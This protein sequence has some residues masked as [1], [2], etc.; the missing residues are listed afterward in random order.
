MKLEYRICYGILNV[1]H[2]S[3][4]SLTILIELDGFLCEERRMNHCGK[5]LEIERDTGMK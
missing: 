3:I 1:M 4:V 2:N 5:N